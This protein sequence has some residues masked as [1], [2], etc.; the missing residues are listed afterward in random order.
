MRTQRLLMPQAILMKPFMPRGTTQR[1]TRPIRL[2]WLVVEHWQPVVCQRAWQK[3]AALFIDRRARE[4][5]QSHAALTDARLSQV[6]S[7]C[8][9]R[10][11]LRTMIARGAI[12]IVGILVLP[13]GGMPPATP[14]SRKLALLLK[15]LAPLLP[16]KP[17]A[18]P[19][20]VTTVTA[21]EHL[22]MAA[23]LDFRRLIATT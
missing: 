22:R 20:N 19:P 6:M 16:D 9:R 12:G 21:S 8:R 17:C 4:Q 14:L 11:T 1:K 10:L 18:Q 23:R 2:R 3:N 7:Q 13:D 15:S 5:V